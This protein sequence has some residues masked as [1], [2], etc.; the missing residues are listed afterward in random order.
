MAIDDD[1]V[2][3]VRPVLQI[4]DA[5]RTFVLEARAG[6]AG[7]ERLA[8]YLEVSGEAD[9]AYTY[10]MWFE[11]A[12]DAGAGDAV[13]HHDELAVVVTAPSIAKVSGA[14]LDVADQ[15]GGPGLVIVNPNSPPAAPLAAARREADLSS[16]L[17][18]AIVAVL[19]DVVNPQIAAHGGRADLVAVEEGVAYLR[20]GG[21]CQ[22]CGLAQVTLSQGISVAIKDAVPGITDVVDVTAHDAGTNPYFESAKK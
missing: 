8:L 7:A 9:G 22:G 4:T 3:D 18:Q 2:S 20:L 1:G 15:G 12:A 19:E 14:T 16:P 11:A 13:H 6:E 17:A 21:G 5:A 10:D